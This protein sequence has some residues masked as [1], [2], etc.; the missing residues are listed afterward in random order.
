M[1]RTPARMCLFVPLIFTSMCT[2]AGRSVGR[3]ARSQSLRAATS[4]KNPM[5][6]GRSAENYV[7]MS[8]QCERVPEPSKPCSPCPYRAAVRVRMRRVRM[9]P[10]YRNHIH[11]TDRAAP[12]MPT[13]T[14]A[15]KCAAHLTPTKCA[16]I[17]ICDRKIESYDFLP[18]FECDAN[19]FL[20]GFSV[21][22]A[23]LFGF[24][25]R[26]MDCCCCCCCSC[27]GCV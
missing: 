14:P 17:F 8:N 5:P 7:F 20:Y 10:A 25:W 2:T 21:F 3:R 9:R 1:L 23:A 13:P 4:P 18:R 15:R 12:A 6:S 22:R 27:C 19:A 24:A 16:D 26:L 11:D